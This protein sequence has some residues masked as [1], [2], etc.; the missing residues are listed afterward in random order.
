MHI[1]R[2]FPYLLVP[3]HGPDCES[4]DWNEVE[5]H[6]R[7][8]ASS[9]DIAINSTSN[10]K[11]SKREHVY[12]IILV[13]AKS[14]YGYHEE[15]E[16]FMKIYLYSP[17]NL[18]RASE[19]LQSGGVMQQVFQPHE[20]HV[21]YIL[22]VFMDYNLHGM[23]LIH[24][25]SCYFRSPLGKPKSAP[26]LPQIHSNVVSNKEE[27]R[28]TDTALLSSSQV[29]N[30]NWAAYKE[31]RDASVSIEEENQTSSPSVASTQFKNCSHACADA[32]SRTLGNTQPGNL[33]E[34][35]DLNSSCPLHIVWSQSTIPKSAFLPPE[36]ER[37][38]V[39]ELEVDVLGGDIL[40][41]KDLESAS[42]G[43]PGIASI[44]ED[45]KVRRRERMESSQIALDKSQ[46]PRSGVNVT[47]KEDKYIYDLN[48]ALHQYYDD[49]A[50]ITQLEDSV[51]YESMKPSSSPTSI[52]EVPAS[53]H[54]SQ[55][56]DPEFTKMMGEMDWAG[57]GS[58]HNLSHIET[59]H[60]ASLG[61][62][63]QISDDDN[64][65]D[66]NAENVLSH[67]SYVMTQPWESGIEDFLFDVEDDDVII[68]DVIPQ[69]DGASDEQK[70]PVKKR[71]GTSRRHTYHHTT[72]PPITTLETDKNQ[73]CSKPMTTTSG[74]QADVSENFQNSR[75][76]SSSDPELA[77]KSK[78]TVDDAVIL[79]PRAKTK[80][81]RQYSVPLDKTLLE[82]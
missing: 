18:K 10:F 24:A 30:F 54:F 33:N 12:N 9:L 49:N 73:S 70:E 74:V 51:R 14:Y 62:N 61:V 43:N 44:W 52:Y 53:F 32:L 71:L 22:Q 16:I 31:Q 55:D 23:N 63:D 39:C 36:V 38:S 19:A 48:V 3:Y 79:L 60:S 75:R 57:P 28:T 76:L 41:R 72:P 2:I 35:S 27:G 68:D 37:E 47:E 6:L 50:D 80:F 66:R 34:Q 58:Q 8:L 78:K 17:A 25:S 46:D 21:P 42:G 4:A 13:R 56:S 1:H 77:K 69:L 82:T 11:K 7:Q 26:V 40:N 59:Q 20:A 67:E 15:D 5:A 29:Q 64:D 65:K 81:L 45:E